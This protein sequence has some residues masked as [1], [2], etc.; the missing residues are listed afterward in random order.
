MGLHCVDDDRKQKAYQVTD[1]GRCIGGCS[2]VTGCDDEIMAISSGY[3]DDL[4]GTQL[5]TELVKAAIA[6]ELAYFED[7]EV[8]T[9]VP[10]TDARKYTGK[11]PISVRWVHTN[12]GDDVAPNMRAR[13]VAR[14]MRNQGDEAIFAPTPPLETL[15]TVL[16]LAM[17]KLPG[18][19]EKCY[20]PASEQ[21]MQ[22]SLI[23]ISR[24]YFNARVDPLNPTYV[25]LP[26]EH[27]QAG[28]GLCGRLRR[29][30]YG[31]R[32]ADKVGKTSILQPYCRWASL[33]DWH[34]PAYST[35]EIV[36][37]LLLY[38]ETISR[39]WERNA[40]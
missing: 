14:E 37:Y 32:H 31:T 24:A 21:R 23:D 17:T 4:T 6:K 22:I 9:L 39:L 1:K 28:Q 29:H 36:N 7:K 11:E 27:P 19:A 8:W 25:D 26:P 13:L 5:D 20:D 3:V 30:M 2:V 15:R 33:R 34:V 10:R 35:T 12:K 16:S 18:Q 40:S 38:T